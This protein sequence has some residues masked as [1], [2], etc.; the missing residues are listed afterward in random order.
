MQLDSDQA[1]GL[2]APRLVH[3]R[4]LQITRVDKRDTAAADDL[5]FVSRLDEGCRIFV[6]AKPTDT[7]VMPALYKGRIVAGVLAAIC[8]S[9]VPGSI[10]GGVGE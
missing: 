9:F 2:A 10:V 6:K 3:R 7:N 5:E 8:F 1:D 4:I